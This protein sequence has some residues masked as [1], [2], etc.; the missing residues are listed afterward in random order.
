MSNIHTQR[1]EIRVLK[2]QIILLPKFYEYNLNVITY[3]WKTKILSPY[4][5]TDI[6]VYCLFTNAS[7]RSDFTPKTLCIQMQQWWSFICRGRSSVCQTEGRLSWPSFFRSLFTTRCLS[8]LVWRT[9]RCVFVLV[10]SVHTC[11]YKALGRTEVDTG[12]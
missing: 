11:L 5:H 7:V 9:Q 6:F 1:N 10:S 4:C 3:Q 2:K 12:W 8:H